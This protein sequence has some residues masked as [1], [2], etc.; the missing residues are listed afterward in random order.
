MQIFDMQSKNKMNY[1]SFNRTLKSLKTSDI[2]IETFYEYEIKSFSIDNTIYF[3][4][5]N[6]LNQYNDI[7]NTKYEIYEWF[8]LDSTHRIL[9]CLRGIIEPASDRFDNSS[10]KV[11][12]P[13]AIIYKQF[14]KY[15]QGYWTTDYLLQLILM[16]YD[17]VF[18]LQISLFVANKRRKDNDEIMEKLSRVVPIDGESNWSFFISKEYKDDV[19]IFTTSYSRNKQKKPK[20]IVYNIDNL[21]NGWTLKKRIHARIINEIKCLNYI[22]KS[23]YKYVVD[24]ELYE[25][26]PNYFDFKFRTIAAEERKLLNWRPDIKVK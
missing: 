6:L 1:D 14:D 16:N 10:K 21:A 13:G 19:V 15:N 3:S 26:N 22:D 11:F 2:T 7:H 25:C 9:D 18:A 24:R 17:P 23:R 12:I 20:N 8:K 5:S 4:V